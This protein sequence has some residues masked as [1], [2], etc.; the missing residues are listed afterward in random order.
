MQ[1][2]FTDPSAD[3]CTLRIA[4]KCSDVSALRLFATCRALRKV[5]PPLRGLLI[6]AHVAVDCIH[7]ATSDALCLHVGIPDEGG[8]VGYRSH[9]IIDS[10]S[11][12]HSTELTHL[13]FSAYSV[14][15]P[16]W[17]KERLQQYGTKLDCLQVL[18]V[19]HHLRGHSGDFTQ[20]LALPLQALLYNCSSTIT[21]LFAMT[22]H[23]LC[24]ED[25]LANKKLCLNLEY[26]AMDA[27]GNMPN[28]IG[29]EG[30]EGR[31]AALREACPALVEPPRG[32]FHRPSI[33]DRDKCKAFMDYRCKM[34][35]NEYMRRAIDKRRIVLNVH[36]LSADGCYPQAKGADAVLVKCVA[37]NGKTRASFRMSAQV[38]VKDLR[39][40]LKESL[41]S[42]TASTALVF[43]GAVLDESTDALTLADLVWAI[44]MAADVAPPL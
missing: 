38:A 5:Q 7:N 33:L 2:L 22:P 19:T 41:G 21:T 13:E 42:R 27:T 39:S 24:Y 6:D 12:R 40:Q 18:V 36:V 14:G 8:E 16:H 17:S 4:Q 35:E 15:L 9:W 32:V 43:E 34:Y 11:S 23:G 28:Y 1:K 29:V 31:L 37:L 30:T 26:V 44:D 3:E 25:L 20:A 10:M